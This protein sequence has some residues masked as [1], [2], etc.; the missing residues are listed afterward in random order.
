MTDGNAVESKYRTV[1]WQ[2]LGNVDVKMVLACGVKS[3]LQGIIK[4]SFV[5]A[6]EAQC[7]DNVVLY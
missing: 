6:A 2:P 5:N 1:S 3:A 4:K 7:E